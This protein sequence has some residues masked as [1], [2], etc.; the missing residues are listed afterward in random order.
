MQPLPIRLAAEGGPKQNPSPSVPHLTSLSLHGPRES[1]ILHVP[2]C[3]PIG[4]TQWHSR[5]LLMPG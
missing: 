5:A 3:S 1:Q 4:P 2:S